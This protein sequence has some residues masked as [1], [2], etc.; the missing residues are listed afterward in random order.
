MLDLCMLASGSSGKAIFLATEHTRLLIDAGL[1]GKRI[2][3]ALECIGQSPQSLDGLLLSHDHVDHA[4]GAGVMARRYRL[5]VYAT[6]PTWEVAAGKMG[7]LPSAMCLRL[8]DCGT[9]T[10]KDLTVETF[11][12]PHDAAGP[13]GFIFR[14]GVHSLALV[15]DLGTMTPAILH[16]L[17]GVNVLVMEANHDEEMVQKGTY[18]WSLK[19]RILGERGHLSNDLAARSLAAVITEA[20]THVV[21]AHLSEENNLPSLAHDTVCGR[22]EE[23]GCAPGRRFTVQV[24]RRHEPSCRIRLE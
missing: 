10:F 22:L 14:S 5:P 23:A 16:R 12:V 1:S 7:P 17:R 3:A 13:V 15:T 6:A 21:L 11:P 4:C 20:T 8:P 18:P 24:A 19:K 2:A 9:L